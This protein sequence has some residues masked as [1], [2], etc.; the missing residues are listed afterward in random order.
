[1]ELKPEGAGRALHVS[2]SGV[3]LSGIGRVDEQGHD[4]RRGRAALLRGGGRVFF[5]GQR[6]RRRSI[7]SRCKTTSRIDLYF[8]LITTKGVPP[9]ILIPWSLDWRA[10]GDLSGDSLEWITSGYRSG[11]ECRCRDRA[12]QSSASRSLDRR[13]YRPHPADRCRAVHGGGA[14]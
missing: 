13:R 5:V 14:Q 8:I 6:M 2:G 12:C 7:T 11:A 1:M 3:G 9:R 4:T 10:I